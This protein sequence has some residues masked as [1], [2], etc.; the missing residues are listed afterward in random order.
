MYITTAKFNSVCVERGRR[1]KKGESILYD[2][3]RKKVYCSDS[4]EYRKYRD[5]RDNENESTEG[6]V[7][8]QEEVYYDDWCYRNGI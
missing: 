7:R 2:R 3:E 4:E 8:A 1:I 5:E 6:Y